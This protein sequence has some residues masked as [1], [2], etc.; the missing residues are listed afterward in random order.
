MTN[1]TFSK[2]H[3]RPRYSLPYNS[4]Q[5]LRKGDVQ[6]YSFFSLGWIVVSDHCHTPAAL[7]PGKNR[8]P[9]YRRLGR[10]QSRSGRERK[11]S[12]PTEI[13]SPDRPARI[14]SLYRLSIPGPRYLPE[15]SYSQMT[16]RIATYSEHLS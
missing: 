16:S 11:F 4:S 7:P 1:C 5:R 2:V 10:T 9:L 15:Q 13:R 12:P 8:Y 6:L 3:S 14:E